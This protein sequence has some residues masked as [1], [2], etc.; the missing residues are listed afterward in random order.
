MPGFFLIF[1]TM[2]ARR[3][4]L[5]AAAAMLTALSLSAQRG[6]VRTIGPADQAAFDAI[7]WHWIPLGRGAEAAFAQA[8]LFDSRQSIAIVR[9]P[10]RRLRSDVLVAED[11]TAAVTS[12]LATRAGA[13]AAINGS[14]FK[15]GPKNG[16]YV[17]DAGAVVGSTGAEET[18]R[19]NGIVVFPRGG[20]KVEIFTC[21]RPERYAYASRKA[22]DALVSGP[23]LTENGHLVRYGDS[24]AVYQETVERLADGSWRREE[25]MRPV[26]R[27]SWIYFYDWRHPRTMMGTTRDGMVYLVVVDGRFPGEADGMT[28]LEM[29]YLA[30]WLGL[31]DAIN[32]DGGGSSTLWSGETGVLNNPC[33]NKR[34]DHAGERRVP[35]IVYAY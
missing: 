5:T 35:N 24:L 17:K 6:P 21:D 31:R 12:A 23:M 4:F 3:L 15:R 11:S 25:A 9:Y 18:F 13:M 8:D 7:Q 28:I 26:P 33:D 32:L 27:R 20:R 10:M 30:H 16:T 22:A 19:C 2:R 1:G 29:S 34:Y 14:Y